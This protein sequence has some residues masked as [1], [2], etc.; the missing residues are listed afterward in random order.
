METKDFIITECLKLFL[1]KS[2]KDVTMKEIVEKTGLSKGAFYH[3]FQSKEE[4]FLEIID[5]F[6]TRMVVFNFDRYSK[7]SL[8]QFYHDHLSDLEEVMGQFTHD[9]EQ[10]HEAPAIDMNYFYPMFDAIR[11]FPEYKDKLNRSR[12]SEMEAWTAAVEHARK[13]DEIRSP[14]SDVQIAQLFIFSGN[15][16]GLHSIMSANTNRSMTESYRLLWDALYQSLDSKRPL[17]AN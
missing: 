2:F 11:M 14:L 3:Y 1:Q 5:R 13:A 8:F 12:E 6:F 17:K 10:L 9:R 4:V 15:G 16:M 7:E